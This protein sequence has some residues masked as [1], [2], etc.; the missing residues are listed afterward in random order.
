VLLPMCLL[1]LL[2]ICTPQHLRNAWPVCSRLHTLC[3]LLPLQLAWLLL[4]L[5]CIHNLV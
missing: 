1:L 5:L 4:L 3:W 2:R